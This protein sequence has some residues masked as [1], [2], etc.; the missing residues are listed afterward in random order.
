MFDRS[1]RTW[2]EH[3]DGLI[4]KYWVHYMQASTSVSQCR[5]EGVEGLESLPFLSPPP[6]THMQ[7]VYCFTLQS[8][9]DGDAMGNRTALRGKR[10]R[11]CFSSIINRH[12]VWH[13]S[14]PCIS[15]WSV[16]LP[17]YVWHTT[18]LKHNW[19]TCWDKE[20]FLI[21]QLTRRGEGCLLLCPLL[22]CSEIQ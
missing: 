7:S 20:D 18:A 4:D 9:T 5:R 1:Q 11:K 10:E 13:L 14:L 17:S 2:F 16:Y 8:P 15:L 6:H 12:L 3:A 21:S 19:T 22:K